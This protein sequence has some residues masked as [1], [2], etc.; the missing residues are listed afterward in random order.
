M[1][2]FRAVMYVEEEE[3][4]EEEESE[5]STKCWGH[6]MFTVEFVDV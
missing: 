6:N 3:E 1:L 5:M 2:R 4:E